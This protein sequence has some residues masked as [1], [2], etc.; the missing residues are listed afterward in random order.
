[1]NSLHAARIT[2]AGQ[3]AATL[4]HEISQ[5]LTAIVNSVNAAKAAA[6]KRWAPRFTYRARSHC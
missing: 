2:A 3:M 1:M 5:P 6:Y 4:A